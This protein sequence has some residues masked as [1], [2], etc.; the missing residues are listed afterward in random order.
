MMTSMTW[1]HFLFHWPLWRELTKGQWHL[2]LSLG[3]DWISF[4][5][6]NRVVCDLCSCDVNVMEIHQ[7]QLGTLP[8]WRHQMETFYASLAI[9][10]GNSPVTG[11]IPVQR[12]V[13]QSFDVFFDSAWMNGW[14]SNREAGDLR[15]HCTHYDVTVMA[16]PYKSLKFQVLKTKTVISVHYI[17]H[18]SKMHASI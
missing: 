8:W 13:T 10:A 5:T 18:P 3:L 14:V 11:K 15:R 4:W 6:K 2:V 16:V 1:K 17:K 7:G 9:C 12:P